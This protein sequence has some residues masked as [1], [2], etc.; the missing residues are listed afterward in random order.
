MRRV[1][2][3]MVLG[4]VALGVG[5][6][7]CTARDDGTVALGNDQPAAASDDGAEFSAAGAFV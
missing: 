3:R 4:A 1:P 6:A 5:L 2:T 7:S